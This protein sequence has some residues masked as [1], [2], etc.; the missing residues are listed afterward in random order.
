MLQSG[1]AGW[2]SNRGS[3]HGGGGGIVAVDWKP[4]AAATVVEIQRQKISRLKKKIEKYLIKKKKK[5]E[6]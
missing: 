2:E 3:F 6:K 5:I 1:G 4:Y